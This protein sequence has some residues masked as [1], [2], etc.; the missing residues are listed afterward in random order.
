ME[1][2]KDEKKTLIYEIL[3]TRGK[4]ILKEQLSKFAFGK[5]TIKNG[6]FHINTYFPESIKEYLSTWKEIKFRG[7]L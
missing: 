7:I 4:K 5:V 1:T 2:S 3:N 6:N